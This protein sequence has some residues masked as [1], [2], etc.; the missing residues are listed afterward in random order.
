MPLNIKVQKDPVE[1]RPI[2]DMRLNLLKPAATFIT[3]ALSVML[4]E[5]MQVGLV[6]ECNCEAVG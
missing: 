3:E 4:E 1:T 2:I 6:D 5:K